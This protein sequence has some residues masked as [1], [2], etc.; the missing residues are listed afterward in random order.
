MLLQLDDYLVN[1]LHYFITYCP[2]AQEYRSEV[3]H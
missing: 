1:F 3:S 2:V